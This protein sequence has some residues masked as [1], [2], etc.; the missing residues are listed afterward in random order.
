MPALSGFA[1]P[2]LCA[3]LLAG[4]AGCANSQDT[5]FYVLTPL[6][7]VGHPGGAVVRRPA[8]GLRPVG[9]P[10]YLDRPQIVTRTS[11]NTL[12]LAEFDQWG[13]S[14]QD[15]VTRVL[16]ENIALL[17]PTERVAVFPWMRDNRVEYEIAVE[18]AR[19]DGT[20]GATCSVVAHWTVSGRGG[21]ESLSAGTFSRTEAAGDDYASLVAAY[22]RLIGALARDIATAMAGVAR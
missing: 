10:E 9:L 3:M 7:G 1:A 12:R 5:R 2:A 14:L 4:L 17:V 11:E 13:S 15:N 18:V 21:R 22:S 20:L 19:F 16:A 6:A 8:I